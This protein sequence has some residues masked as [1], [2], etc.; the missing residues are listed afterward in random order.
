MEEEILWRFCCGM[1][2]T[3]MNAMYEVPLLEKQMIES[4][5]KRKRMR[6]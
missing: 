4:E 3:S 6:E 2:P 1:E 5:R